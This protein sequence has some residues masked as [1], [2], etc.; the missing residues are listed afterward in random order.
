MSISFHSDFFSIVACS[1]VGC[2]AQWL[3]CRFLADF[4][5][6][7]CPRVDMWPLCG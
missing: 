1:V 2:G 4:G 7:S 6:L 5:G 3:R